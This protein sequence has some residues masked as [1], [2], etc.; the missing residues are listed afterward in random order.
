M[1]QKLKESI[2]EKESEKVAIER[3]Q[4][5]IDEIEE[6]VHIITASKDLDKYIEKCVNLDEEEG[7]F[8][9]ALRL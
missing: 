6:F 4:K 3:L 2:T 9:K 7:S 8:R 5:E 1:L